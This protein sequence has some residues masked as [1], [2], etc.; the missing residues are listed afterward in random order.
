M[1]L[2]I[3]VDEAAAI[4]TGQHFKLY[5]AESYLWVVLLLCVCLCARVWVCVV[6]RVFLYVDMHVCMFMRVCM[7]VRSY[8]NMHVLLLCCFLLLNMY[9][10][11]YECL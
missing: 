5:N 1:F 4:R 11:E 8:M 9:T 6:V 2:R 3:V 7:G 10:D